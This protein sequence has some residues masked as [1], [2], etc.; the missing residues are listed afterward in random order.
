MEAFTAQIGKKVFKLP[1]F[2]ANYGRKDLK[3]VRGG[4]VIG[5]LG[6]ELFLG[7]LDNFIKR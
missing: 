4:F 5:R 1:F 6:S 2:V 7:A 3:N